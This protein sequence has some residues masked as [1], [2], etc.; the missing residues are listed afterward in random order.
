[1][2]HRSIREWANLAVTPDEDGEGQDHGD[3]ITR[4][5]ANALMAAARTTR[6]GGEDGERVL[7]NG[8]H[9]LRAQQMVG[10]L[11]CPSA[12][13]EILPKIGY[14]NDDAIRRNLVHM[15]ARTLDLKISAGSLASLATQKHDLLEILIRLFC[16]QLFAAVHRGLP[17][18]YIAC[19]DD[20]GVLRG[21]LDA[22]RQ[23][24][25]L[26]GTPQRLACR[27][28]ELSADTP[29]NQI[30]KA[31]V[32]RL[33]T[34]ARASENKRRLNELSFVFSNITRVPI[35]HLPW[36]RVVLDRTNRIWGTLLK[37]AGLLLSKR[38]QTT[39]LGRHHG[40]AL[41]FEMNLLFEEY[42]G[43]LL[44]QK[45]AASVRTIRLQGPKGHAL[46]ADDGSRRFA[47]RPDIVISQGGRVRL[48]IDTK[49]KS[50]AKHANDLQRSV[51]HA[52]VYQMIAY[53]QVYNCDHIMLL[54][55]H[56]LSSTHG[57]QF[58]NSMLGV[59]NRHLSVATVS[60]T[61][62]STV[63]DQLAHLVKGAIGLS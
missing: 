5:T 40:Y 29:L 8:H 30:I 31:A 19:E 11:T 50:L 15:L 27:Y 10:V 58:C 16:D 24:T 56:D 35:R 13:L 20:L 60:L 47:T 25:V 42:V 2:I 12:T 7:V 46:V 48:I 6:L 9:R 51:S 49:W 63:P 41:L 53:G 43:R 38:F 4:S 55:P 54:Y 36:Q 17:R 57:L 26:A 52:D 33:A 22:K 44:R 18:R 21:R 14:L 1:M 23:F 61:D 39:S 59:E 3:S 62:L 37:F 34:V 32:E 28:E 45:L